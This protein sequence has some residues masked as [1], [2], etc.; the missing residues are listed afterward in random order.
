LALSMALH[1]LATNAVKYG[2]FSNHA[3]R[4]DICWT[5]GEDFRLCWTEAN[6]PKVVEPGRRGFGSRLIL[7]GLPHDFGGQVELSFE[8]GGVV[9]SIRAPLDEILASSIQS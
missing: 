7:Q 5:A 1:E 9:C 3:G 4:V 2:A 6:G 8:P